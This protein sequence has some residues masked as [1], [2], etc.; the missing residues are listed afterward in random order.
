LAA[1]TAYEKIFHHLSQIHQSGGNI[2]QAVNHWLK[3]KEVGGDRASEDEWEVLWTVSRMDA[4]LIPGKHKNK[5]LPEEPE[6]P[7]DQENFDLPP[8][9]DQP[10]ED[11]DD[12]FQDYRDKSHLFIDDDEDEEKSVFDSNKV[13]NIPENLTAKEA[14][15]I[16]VGQSLTIPNNDNKLVLIKDTLEDFLT[17]MAATI[18]FKSPKDH[19]GMKKLKNWISSVFQELPQS[20]DY[21]IN[22]NSI[23]NLQKIRKILGNKAVDELEEVILKV[24]EKMFLNK[25]EALTKTKIN[26]N[27]FNNL[28]GL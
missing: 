21:Y 15:K 23:A 20:E 2:R 28:A 16:G 7:E 19:V 22:P 11:E 5:E 27:M 26:P 6:N 18:D 17:Y 25:T 13:N 3:K 1:A 8:D 24:L 14:L 10:P 4:L 12:T 9:N